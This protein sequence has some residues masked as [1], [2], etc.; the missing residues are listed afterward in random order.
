[1]G[2][3]KQFKSWYKEQE[4]KA[5][6][7][8]RAAGR[9]IDEHVFQPLIK[10][11][12]KAAKTVTPTVT[13]KTIRSLFNRR[14]G[15]R[16]LPKKKPA[17]LQKIQ[18]VAKNTGDAIGDAGRAVAKEV[19][20]VV[21]PVAGE[22]AMRAKDLAN[23]KAVKQAGDAIG[24][25][26]RSFDKNVIQPVSTSKTMKNIQG[27]AQQAAD[28]VGQTARNVGDNIGDGIRELP[29]Q[30]KK[31]SQQA[32]GGGLKLPLPYFT[33][34]LPDAVGD[35]A[36]G[37]GRVLLSPFRGNFKNDLSSGIG[38]IGRGAIVDPVWHGIKGTGGVALD[39]A[40]LISKLA[41]RADNKGNT[42]EEYDDVEDGEVIEVDANGRPVASGGA[43][44]TPLPKIP[45]D[46]D[47]PIP[48]SQTVASGGS[49][50][51]S[52]PREAPDT[53]DVMP[54]GPAGPPR[55]PS[56][57]D[58]SKSTPTM[59]ALTGGETEQLLTSFYTEYS[60]KASPLELINFKSAAE[61]GDIQKMQAIINK[62]NS[63]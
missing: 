47:D 62:I 11:T 35:I 21:N 27:K 2:R 22:I 30:L 61:A 52:P 46:T 7:G 5:G 12:Q 40:A 53:D 57:I 3:L 13:A 4:D 16:L 6:D 54:E 31:A 43:G 49:Q 37:T 26:L 36:R 48:S 41:T 38:M 20:H 18:N 50:Q 34:I 33:K 14:R 8:V 60:N 15:P 19:G 28:S 17:V 51:S 55:P 24:D 56:P 45:D 63:R 42:V 59:N 44:V 32:G 1:M 9:A 23:S 25:G 29:S 10:G 58:A 39:T